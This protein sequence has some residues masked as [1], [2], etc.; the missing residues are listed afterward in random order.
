ML[1]SSSLLSLV[2][3]PPERLTIPSA[4]L[5]IYHPNGGYEREKTTICRGRRSHRRA[6]K[7]FGLPLSIKFQ[8]VSGFY[9]QGAGGTG[10]GHILAA[11][12]VICRGTHT[13]THT[14]T[15]K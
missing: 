7:V 4:S 14:H 15:P 6:R 3:V 2:F 12:T 1:L 8:P 11:D 13:H 9:L 5:L 10:P